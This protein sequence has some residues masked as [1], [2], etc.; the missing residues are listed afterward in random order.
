MQSL[1]GVAIAH[2]EE[3]EKSTKKDP[4]VSLVVCPSTLVGHWMNEMEKMFPEGKCF[5]PLLYVGPAKKRKAA[6]KS[7]MRNCNVVVTSYSVLRTDIDVLADK[8]WLCTI[9]DEG[10]LLKN[11]KSGA[12]EIFVLS[13][14]ALRT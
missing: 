5:R 1:I 12:L 7:G 9:L 4:P 6:W 2:N 10:H 8:T 14:L 3:Q 13:L 11:P